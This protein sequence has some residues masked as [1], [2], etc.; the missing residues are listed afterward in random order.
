VQERHGENGS[1]SL[2]PQSQRA[3][4]AEAVTSSGDVSNVNRSS[5]ENRS[6]ERGVM[7]DRVSVTDALRLRHRAVL[8]HQPM[9][10]TVD[11]VDER[12]RGLAELSRR[13]CDRAEHAAEVGRSTIAEPSAHPAS[14][15][16]AGQG[17]KA[18]ISS[19][20]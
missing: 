11:Q 3:E 18:V 4:T 20:P 10:I 16:A 15:A 14:V 5:I 17:V 2:D 1:N 8:R 13:P 19:E 9:V 12:V 6:S 7:A